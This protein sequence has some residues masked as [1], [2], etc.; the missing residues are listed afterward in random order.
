MYAQNAVLVNEFLGHS[1]S[2]KTANNVSLGVE[3]IR[4]SGFFPYAYWYWIGAGALVGFTLLF[5]VMYTAGLAHLNRTC[6]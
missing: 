5:N 2:Q 1:W 3:I 4:N 6:L